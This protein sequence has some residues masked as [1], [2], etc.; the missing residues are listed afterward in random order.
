MKKYVPYVAT[1][2][3]AFAFG[4][5]IVYMTTRKDTPSLDNNPSKEE[6]KTISQSEVDNKLYPLLKSTYSSRSYQKNIVTAT[7]L[8][9]DQISLGVVNYIVLNHEDE[10]QIKNGA[11]TISLATINKYA[12]MLYGR[13]IDKLPVSVAPVYSHNTLLY[14]DDNSNELTI[15]MEFYSEGTKPS[16]T[17]WFTDIKDKDVIYDRVEVS[18]DEVYVYDKTILNNNISWSGP[19]QTGTISKFDGT[20]TINCEQNCDIKSLYKNHP[21][22]FTTYKHI[23]KMSSE[24]EYKYISSEPVL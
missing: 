8:T 5:G 9:V 2:L 24:G 13:T 15:N 1:T 11:Y 16:E 23:F 14:G 19:V 18:K 21:D 3:I 12:D 6:E 17:S 4:A 10:I 20:G 7:D 22:Y